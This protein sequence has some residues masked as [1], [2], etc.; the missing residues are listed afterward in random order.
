MYIDGH[1]Y[2]HTYNINKWVN[3]LYVFLQSWSDIEYSGFHS[4]IEGREIFDGSLAESVASVRYYTGMYVQTQLL[5]R[6]VYLYHVHNK[7][8]K[9]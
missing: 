2:V 3:G 1:T 5:Q 4:N 8:F 7:T 6:Y 9:E